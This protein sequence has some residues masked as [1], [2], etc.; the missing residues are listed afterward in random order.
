MQEQ[1]NEIKLEF[2][3]RNKELAMLKEKN[4][5]IMEENQTLSLKFNNNSK[6][7][8]EMGDKI[9]KLQ[10]QCENIINQRS[11]EFKNKLKTI[12]EHANNLKIKNEKLSEELIY[13]KKY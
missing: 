3:D 1:Y 4:Q 8:K 9:Q 6:L 13:Y 7:E 12:D 2:E 5:N 10:S 11:Q